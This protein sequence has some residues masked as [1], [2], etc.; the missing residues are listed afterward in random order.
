MRE[1]DAAFAGMMQSARYGNER[2][3]VTVR[4]WLLVCVALPLAVGVGASWAHDQAAREQDAAHSIAS[5]GASFGELGAAK[6]ITRIV[7]IHMFDAMRFSPAALTFAQGE[8][9]RLHIVNEGKLPHEFVLGTRQ[10]IDEHEDMMRKMPGMVHADASSV[11]VASGMS[12]DVVWK[13]SQPGNFLYACLVPGHHEAGMQGVVTVTGRV[14][15]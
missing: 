14:E 15:R 5:Q 10:E 6:D 13:F 3:N 1:T 8:T 9:V 11:N 4:T 2:M 12:A 7:V